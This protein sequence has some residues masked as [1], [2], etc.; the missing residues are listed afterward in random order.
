ME[1]NGKRMDAK[2]VLGKTVFFLL[3]VAF[4]VLFSA[5]FGA[6][7]S[8]I[9]VAV[10]VAALMMLGK[11]LTVRPLLSFGGLLVICLALGLGAFIAALN[12]WIGLPVNFLLVFIIM[13]VM[14]HDLKSPFWFPFILGYAFIL[15]MPVPA[16]ALPLRLLSLAVGAVFIF[17]LN[18]V[19]NR[20]RQPRTVQQAVIALIGS[21]QTAVADRQAGRTPAP[22]AV[23]AATAAAVAQFYG[24]VKDR[25]FLTAPAKA[26]ID[27]AAAF[28]SLG[29]AV[30]ACACRPAELDALAELLDRLA[31]GADGPAAYA[32]GRAEVTRF[33]AEQPA[34]DVQL[35]AALELIGAALGKLADGSEPAAAR[36][37]I[38]PAFRLSTFLRTNLTADSMKFTFAFRMAF[39]IALWSFIGA[40]FALEN[41]K[42]LVFTS[43]AIVMP[44]LE[45]SGRKSLLRLEGTAVGVVVFL[46]LMPLL[47]APAAI[48]LLMLG[49]G[50]VYTLFD[51]M[52]YRR[53]MAFNTVSALLTALMIDPGAPI[54]WERIIY[55]VGGVAAALAANRLLLPYRIRDENAELAG[56]VARL[57]RA[58]LATAEAALR[59]A[60][61][62]DRAA[63]L[64]VQA[65]AVAGK[66]RVNDGQEPDPT[67]E[68]LLLAQHQLVLEGAALRLTLAAASAGEK[69]AAAGLF[70]GGEAAAPVGN[71]LVWRASAVVARGR[72]VERLASRVGAVRTPLR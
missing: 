55:I 64:A 16:D 39:M 31:A 59:G 28:G 40:Y 46:L 49:I 53:Q 38:P 15:A 44:Y 45:G 10:I 47:T 35:R 30:A 37:S 41:A 20:A 8:L 6:A 19:I 56:K 11:D 29:Q 22:E 48:S 52:G 34:A 26:V 68:E 32:A 63:A 3:L 25:Y 61:D 57:A 65:F 27:L 51:P 7:N 66:L 72:E 13:Y 5:A 14:L 42:W 12:P 43:I 17:G 54:V 4:M 69:E 50:Y 36:R 62:T 58:Q 18:A 21:L 60:D 33:L 71:G 2:F 24:E 23:E 67:V 1:Y 70:A 9:G